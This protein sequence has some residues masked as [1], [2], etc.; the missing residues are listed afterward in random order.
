[1]FARPLR[2][3]L[4]KQPYRAFSS[5]PARS[6]DF[7]HV[8]IG[9][10]AVGL[11]IARKL[12]ERD[13]TSTLLIERHGSVIHAGLYYGA[14]SLKTSLCLRGKE[15][16]YALCARH[17]IPHRNTGKWIVAQDAQQMDALSNLHAFATSVSVP[18]HFLS[19]AT[20]HARE[21]SVRALAGVLESPTTGI[22]DS[23]ALM[24][25]LEGSF[26]TLGGE[27]ALH[28]A[29][30]NIEP[31]PLGG[32]KIYTSSDASTPSSDPSPI[33]TSTLINSAGLAAIPLSNILLPPP[34]PHPLL[35]QRLLLQLRLLLPPPLHPRLPRPAPGPR[36]PRHPPH[37]RHGR[38]HALRPG[39]RVGVGPDGSARQRVPAGG[40]AR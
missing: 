16:L 34:P 4:L 38:P 24:S 21:P 5:S 8:V 28:T 7:T 36:R 29:V 14:D 39:R 33:T 9:A 18:T 19:P 13:G 40:G 30:T 23:H 37:A 2:S 31:L 17:N 1:M 3:R 20:A 25:H 35:R 22:I 12:A 26:Q 10:G 11:A 6:A 15:M 32:Y 27:L